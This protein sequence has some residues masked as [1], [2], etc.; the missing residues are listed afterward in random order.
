MRNRATG[1]LDIQTAGRVMMG[2]GFRGG[3]R[4][5]RNAVH[6]PAATSAVEFTALAAFVYFECSLHSSAMTAL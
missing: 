3:A 1:R 5:R 2:F 6:R 4:S